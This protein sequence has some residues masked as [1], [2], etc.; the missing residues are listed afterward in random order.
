MAALSVEA[1]PKSMMDIRAQAG[2]LSWVA[3]TGT[4]SA[5]AAPTLRDRAPSFGELFS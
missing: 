2:Q 1:F 4:R 5:T 3:E